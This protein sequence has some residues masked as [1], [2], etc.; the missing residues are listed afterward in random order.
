MRGLVARD[1]GVVRLRL[2][3]ATGTVL[4]VAA[5]DPTGH[6][7]ADLVPFESRFVV[8]HG[9]AAPEAARFVVVT[10]GEGTP[11][12]GIRHPYASSLFLVV[13]PRRVGSAGGAG[14]PTPGTGPLPRPG[15]RSIGND[16]LIGGIVFGIPMSE[17]HGP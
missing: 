7:H 14:A 1:I 9:S 11:L 12:D 13:E 10:D 3:S 17:R 6:G 15:I 2:E 8:E 5:I 4:A 16:G